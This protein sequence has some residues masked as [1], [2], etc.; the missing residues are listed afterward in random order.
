MTIEEL[1]QGKH[2]TYNGMAAGLSAHLLKIR[3]E[4][5][6]TKLNRSMPWSTA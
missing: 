6:R 2:N 1:V 5:I 3:K 4:T